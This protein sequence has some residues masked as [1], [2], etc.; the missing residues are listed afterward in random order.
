M[1]E[2]NSTKLN[3]ECARDW[4]QQFNDWNQM[5]LKED[6]LENEDF[7]LVSQMQWQRL[8]RFFGGA[9]E[10]SFFLVEKHLLVTSNSEE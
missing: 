2:L 8:S 5:K 9:P 4:P 3:A 6:L 10:I 7:V 1:N